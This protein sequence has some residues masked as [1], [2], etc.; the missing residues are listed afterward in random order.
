MC[1][2]FGDETD[3]KW[4]REHNLNMKIIL[5]KYGKLDLS[6]YPELNGKKANKETRDLISKM[7]EEKGFVSQPRKK[8]SH[9]VKCA[10]RFWCAS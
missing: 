10:E 7:L 3:I 1:C 5:N 6:E 9:V 2:T 8:I 4:W